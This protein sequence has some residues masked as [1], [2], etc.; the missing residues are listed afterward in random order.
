MIQIREMEL[1]IEWWRIFSENWFTYHIVLLLRD[2]MVFDLE[3]N[4]HVGVLLNRAGRL[5]LDHE[6]LI[7]VFVHEIGGFEI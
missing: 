5:T 4:E 6:F 1:A 7:R 3:A 2:L